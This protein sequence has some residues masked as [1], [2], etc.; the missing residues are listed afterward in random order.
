MRWFVQCTEMT[1]VV[2]MCTKEIFDVIVTDILVTNV[3]YVL[4]MWHCQDQGPEPCQVSTLLL[5]AGPGFQ[6][7]GLPHPKKQWKSE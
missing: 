1:D 6:L 3:I 7:I 5:L 2:I 4:V